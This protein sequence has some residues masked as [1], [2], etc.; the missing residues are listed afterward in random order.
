[1][2]PSVAKLKGPVLA[3]SAI[4]DA[5][6][7]LSTLIIAVLFVRAQAYLAAILLSGNIFLKMGPAWSDAAIGKLCSTRY[8]V[9]KVS[10]LITSVFGSSTGLKKLPIRWD[11]VIALA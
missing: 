5:V 6:F 10:A 2:D 4:S 11:P 3:F 9:N 8:P 7:L 1:M